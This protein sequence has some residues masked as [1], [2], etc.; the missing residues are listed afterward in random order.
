[1]QGLKLLLVLLS[2]SR[3]AAQAATPPLAPASTDNIAW[4]TSL[5]AEAGN[6]GTTSDGVHLNSTDGIPCPVGN[7]Q[8]QRDSATGIA[9]DASGNSVVVGSYRGTMRLGSNTLTSTGFR[10]NWDAYV[11][12]LSPDGAV[13]HAR[14]FHVTVGNHTDPALFLRAV[15]VNAATSEIIIMGDFRGSDLPLNSISLQGPT[16]AFVAVLS[17]QLTVVRAANLVGGGLLTGP[18][19]EDGT[20]LPS[21]D[22]VLILGWDQTSVGHD[23]RSDMTMSFGADSYSGYPNPNPGYPNARRILPQGFVAVVDATTLVPTHSA[24]TYGMRFS[25]VAVSSSQLAFSGRMSTMGSATTASFLSASIQGPVHDP[26]TDIYHHSGAV[27]ATCDHALTPPPT[28]DVGPQ[29]RLAVGSALMV[30]CE[31]TDRSYY[32]ESGGVTYDAAG[33]L[34]VAMSLSGQCAFGAANNNYTIGTGGISGQPDTW[35]R[36]GAVVSL[37]PEL[38][39]IG[40]TLFAEGLAGSQQSR[41]VVTGLELDP[42]SGYVYAAGYYRGTSVF[43]GRS[44]WGGPKRRSGFVTAIDTS[45]GNVVSTLSFHALGGTSATALAASSVGGVVFAGSY[46]GSGVSFAGGQPANLTASS[47]TILTDTYSYDTGSYDYDPIE[48][49]PEGDLLRGSHTAPAR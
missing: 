30:V 22:I 21:G 1:M 19:V 43:G 14:D 16:N 34:A 44:V 10:N 47:G 17:P 12:V 25:S 40:S 26:W 31:A 41:P 4:S 33:N 18:T 46:T 15:T 9:I 3:G 49:T 35:N 39:V 20:L 42:T 38:A 6:G 7:G 29:R 48:T 45:N 37:T 23:E 24:A 5:A 36:T 8:C 32:A 28:P 2:L 13:L 27:V 11:A